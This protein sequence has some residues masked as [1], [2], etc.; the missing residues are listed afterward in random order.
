MLFTEGWII[1]YVIKGLN[2]PRLEEV[3]GYWLLEAEKLRAKA[4]RN[5][6]L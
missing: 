1:K 2:L 6:Q 5:L 3:N 4:S